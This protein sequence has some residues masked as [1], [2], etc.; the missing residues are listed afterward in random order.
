MGKEMPKIRIGDSFPAARLLDIDGATVESAA[1]FAQ[2]PAT[3]VFFYRS[4]W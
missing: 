4:R 1:A 3:V 2:A